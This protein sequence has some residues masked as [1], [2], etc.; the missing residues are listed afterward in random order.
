MNRSGVRLEAGSATLYFTAHDVARLELLR[1]TASGRA[2]L[3]QLAGVT[4]AG[5]IEET[6]LLRAV[7]EA[8]MTAIH[9]L[10]LD[11]GYAAL[12]ADRH[13]VV[14]SAKRRPGRRIPVWADEA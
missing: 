11:N 6:A 12:A 13:K 3:A 14:K 5:E 4:D 9:D 7:F 1:S 2:A 10:A 8:G